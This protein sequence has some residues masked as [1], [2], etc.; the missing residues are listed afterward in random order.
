[1]YSKLIP[2]V[3][4]TVF[5]SSCCW[6][7]KVDCLEGED[8]PFT[9]A[10]NY[11]ADSIIQ[12]NDTLEIN[13][14]TADFLNEYQ[15][16][17]YDNTYFSIAVT[18]FDGNFTSP[19]NDR[20]DVLYQ[21]VELLGTNSIEGY[22]G[23]LPDSINMQIAFPIPGYYL[24]Q[25]YGNANRYEPDDSRRRSRCSCNSNYHYLNF[26]FE[27]NQANDVWLP[28]YAQSFNYGIDTYALEQQGAYFIKVE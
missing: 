11:S 12:S 21:N 5:L 19:A 8:A 13:I 6:F 10:V 22:D 15:E 16:K 14:Q 23:P 1:M 27:A 28:V 3:F 20:I 24:I 18:W 9:L 17:N 26:Q 4:L 25:F 7:V 2:F